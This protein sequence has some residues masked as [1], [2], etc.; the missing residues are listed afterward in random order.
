[1]LTSGFAKHNFEEMWVCLNFFKSVTR[2]IFRYPRLILQMNE[3]NIVPVSRAGKPKADVRDRK[4]IACTL[5]RGLRSFRKEIVPALFRGG[6]QF[7]KLGGASQLRP[8]GIVLQT[9]VSAKVP[10]NRILQQLHGNVSL[11]A[12]KKVGRNHVAGFGIGIGE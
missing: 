6:E 2:S 4:R 12:K 3:V 1:M 7:G 9:R 10:G 8:R 11:S 5:V